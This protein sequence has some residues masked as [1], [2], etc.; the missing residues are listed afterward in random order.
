M[1]ALLLAGL[2][3]LAAPSP[4]A[5][6]SPVPGYRVPSN[7]DLTATADMIL[8]AVVEGP[9]ASDDPDARRVR[10]R[11][12]AALK[13]DAADAPAT[14]P[15]GLASGDFALLSNPYQLEQAHPLAYAGG[16]IRTMVPRGS[17]LLFFLHRQGGDWVPAGGP[18]SRWAED[19]LAD[20]APWLRA[21][22]FYLRVLALPEGERAAALTTRRGEWRAMT[23]DPV[24]QLLADE[25]GRQIA[26][27]NPP[28]R[29]ELPPPPEE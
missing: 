9:A 14:L 8:L 22:R 21:V 13:G 20:D 6:C 24:A 3:L 23:D 27:P 4:A 2:A 10:I 15:V 12:V 17:R 1:R 28:L 29:A 16:C 11:P 7:L 5:A 26:G 18:F 25:V 19:V